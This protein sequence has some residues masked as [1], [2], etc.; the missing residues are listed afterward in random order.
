MAKIYKGSSASEVSNAA[1]ARKG[2][3]TISVPYQP[4]KG[5]AKVVGTKS[6]KSSSGKN[7]KLRIRTAK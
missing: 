1:R 2:R 5:G 6:R 7:F 4:L 3:G